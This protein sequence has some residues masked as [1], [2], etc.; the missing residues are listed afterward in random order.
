MLMLHEIKRL[1]RVEAAL[2]RIP[3]AERML[4]LDSAQVGLT[5]ILQLFLE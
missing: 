4:L 5:N 3:D 2:T 1:P